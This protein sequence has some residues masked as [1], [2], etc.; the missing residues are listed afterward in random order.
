[1]AYKTP[2]TN[3]TGE[4]MPGP[5]AKATAGAEHGYKVADGDNIAD[6]KP[7]NP[8]FRRWYL[9]LG[10]VA[11]VYAGFAGLH[12]LSD[13][14][15]WWQLATARWIVQHHHIPSVDVFSYT[16]AGQPWIYPVGSGLIFYAV[17]LAGSYSLLSW[18]GAVTCVGTVALLLRRGSW[19]TA[20]LAILAVPRIALRSTPRAEI[21]SVLLFAA[22]FTLLWEQY[23]TGRARLW[24]LPPMMAAWVNLHLGLTAGLGLMAGYVLLECMEMAWPAHR[25]MALDHLRRA[26]PWFLATIAVTLINPWGWRVFSITRTLMGPMMDRA[27]SIDEWGP[28]KLDW[29]G[30]ASGLSLYRQDSTVMLLL[31]VM[32]AV[33]VALIRR[34]F[35]AAVWL[36]GAAYL[37]LR[38]S[39]LL[40]FFAIVVVIVAGSV[41]NSALVSLQRRN[42]NTRIYGVLTNGACCFIVLLA[43]VWSADLVTNRAYMRR[44]GIYG[45]ASFGTGRG[46]W[47][48]EGAVAFIERERIPG[49]IFNTDMEGGYLVWRL[50]QSYKDYVDSRLYPFSQKVIEHSLRLPQTAPNSP[51]W[52]REAERYNINAIIVP[53]GRYWGLDHFPVLRQFCFSNGWPPVYLDETS[54]VFVRRT[55][56]T[57]ELIGRLQIHCDTVP[58]PA[59]APTGNDGKAFNQ[60]ANA[61]AVLNALGRAPEALAATS[62]AMSIFPDSGSLRFARAD[63][64]EKLGDDSDAEREY[65]AS[66]RLGPDAANWTR[67]AELYDREHRVQDS[68]AAR[69]NAIEMS[70]DNPFVPLLS[71]GFEYLGANQ[72]SDALDAFAR[73]RSAFQAEKGNDIEAHKPY[74]ATLARGQAAAYAALHDIRRAISLEEE[75][76][77]LT[78]ERYDDW[79]NLGKLYSLD[80]R[81]DDAERANRRAAELRDGRAAPEE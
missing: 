41:F 69:K 57:E 34:Q 19:A 25:R 18:L 24:L 38:H 68:I 20:A 15:L 49:Q 61:A 10:L 79:L 13:P 44:A 48:P 81:P 43:C 55:P 7:P 3:R 6:E 72:P 30:F 64:F 11:L 46:W 50:G 80:G 32:L 37:G 70:H 62:K 71:L 33:P 29:I 16:A 75:A 1:L 36:C 4:G 35:G 23:E 53:L 26:W 9:L 59:S 73:S 39:R 51:E 74:Y 58:I 8:T 14:D 65:L 5:P 22:F 21:F 2:E 77:R 52:Q 67:L 56:A 17:Y 60:W 78:P 31:A 66:A 40:I 12:T 45:M 54:A 63:L 42:K 47:F 76:V 28:V 27:V